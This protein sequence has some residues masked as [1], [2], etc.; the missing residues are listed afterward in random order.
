MRLAR[1]TASAT[2]EVAP[3]RKVTEIGVEKHYSVKELAEL[4]NLSEKTIRRIFEDEPGVLKW[5]DAEGR[6]RR[7]YTTIRIPETIA[8]R[9]HRQHRVAG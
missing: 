2:G 5:G 6:F 3:K 1:Q 4:W 8:L 9:V 7:R